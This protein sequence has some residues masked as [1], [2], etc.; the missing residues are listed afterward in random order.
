MEIEQ[1]EAKNMNNIINLKNLFRKRYWV[2]NYLN[3]FKDGDAAPNLCGYKSVCSNMSIVDAF[4]NLDDIQET[5]YTRLKDG[6]YHSHIIKRGNKEIFLY[7]FDSAD[8]SFVI[9]NDKIYF[10]TG[11]MR[12]PEITPNFFIKHLM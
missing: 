8:D 2:L 5:V 1:L 6:I 9:T 4:D 12:N 7:L 10:N 3:K 11:H